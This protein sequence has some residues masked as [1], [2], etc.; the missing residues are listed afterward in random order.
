[1]N[2]GANSTFTVGGSDD[3]V[4]HGG[5]TTLGSSSSVLA[6][7]SGHSVD[8][9]GGTLQGFGT[10]Q[11]NLSNNGGLVTPGVSGTAGVLTVTGNYA[12]PPSSHLFIQIGGPNT[13][14]GLSQLD[15]GGTA[16]LNNGALD[17]SLV[18]GFVP[19]YGETFDILNAGS[20]VS[21]MFADNWIVVGSVNFEVAY[22]VNAPDGF[23]GDVVLTAVPEPS[24]VVMLPIGIA[25]LGVY[26]ARRATRARAA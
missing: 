5:T 3:Y 24:S 18:N 8:I 22:N 20:L 7:A 1:V 19:A 4:Q 23:A 25:V 16:T 12:D 17:V 11:G 14:N 15:V 21:G 6:V 9:N 13:M 26:A 10:I 2:I